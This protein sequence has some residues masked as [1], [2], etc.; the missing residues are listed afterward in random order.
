LSLDRAIDQR[1]DDL[2]NF[3]MAQVT[4][5]GATTVTVALP[6]GESVSIARLGTW[7]P[8][9]GDVVV[10]AM[11]SAGWVALGPLD[12]GASHFGV[13]TMASTAAT[14]ALAAGATVALSV[15]AS[16]IRACAEVTVGTAA[17]GSGGTVSSA[18][19][20]GQTGQYD[21]A[22]SVSYDLA[23]I[24]TLCTSYFARDGNPAGGDMWGFNR[25]DSGALSADT[26]NS[27]SFSHWFTAGDKIC[28]HLSANKAVTVENPNRRTRV[29]IRYVGN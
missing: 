7:T 3:R 27:N 8:S 29:S 5:V 25:F 26:G 19:T 28:L 6:G 4:A 22:Y 1:I 14:Q 2:R 17:A 24:N 12:I 20:L 9:A 11:T 23:P 10:V 13:Y 18:F 16:V 21:I 15:G